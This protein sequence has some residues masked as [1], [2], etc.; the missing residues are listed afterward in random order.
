MKDG[1]DRN[2]EGYWIASGVEVTM[3]RKT[4]SM[5]SDP[6]LDKFQ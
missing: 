2:Y 5:E 3:L 4:D 6:D 1:A